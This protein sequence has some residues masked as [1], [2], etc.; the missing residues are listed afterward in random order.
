MDVDYGQEISNYTK[1]QT[2]QQI[3]IQ[4]LRNTNNI[5]AQLAQSIIQRILTNSLQA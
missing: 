1:A 4:V 5:N 3:S 2:L